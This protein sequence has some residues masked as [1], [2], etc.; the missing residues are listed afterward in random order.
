MFHGGQWAFRAT[1][2]I[3]YVCTKLG[4]FVVRARARLEQPTNAKI[5]ATLQF[6]HK[7]LTRTKKSVTLGKVGQRILFSTIHIWPN[8]QQTEI[9][10]TNVKPSIRWTPKRRTLFALAAG[11][12][13]LL[14]APYGVGSQWGAIHIDL[15]WS[16]FIPVFVA[17]ALGWRYAL[18]VGLAGGVYHPFVLWPNNGWANLGTSIVYLGL[19]LLVGFFRHTKLRTWVPGWGRRFVLLS[20]LSMLALW[21]YFSFV[22]DALLLLNPPWWRPDALRSVPPDLL[23]AFFLKDFI[24]LVLLFVF[25]DTL[26]QLP[27]VR[28]FFAL[29]TSAAQAN[30]HNIFFLSIVG[31]VV[32]FGG[33]VLVYRQLFHPFDSLDNQKL[34]LLLLTPIGVGFIVAR[35]VFYFN[36]QQYIIRRRL[37]RTDARYRALFRNAPDGI[38][39]LHRRRIS[40][41]N[42]SALQLFRA[43]EGYLNGTELLKLSPSYQNE[44]KT[45]A[46]LLANYFERAERGEAVH[47]EWLFLRPD[48]SYLEAEVSLNLLLANDP[49]LMQATLRDVSEKKH[50]LELLRQKNDAIAAANDKYRSANESL[51]QANQKL[52]DAK[53]TA[54]ENEGKFRTLFESSQEAIGLIHNG[55][56][57]MLN[58]AFVRLFGCSQASEVQH[59]PFLDLISPQAQPAIRMRLQQCIDTPD[60]VPM[61]ESCGRRADGSA[62]DFEGHLGRIW[63]ESQWHVLAILRDIGPR[64]QHEAELLQSHQQ[65]LQ[66]KEQ[67]E[68]SD[69]LKTAFLHN[70]SHE[71]RTPMNA[72][73]GFAGMLQRPRLTDEKRLRYTQVVMEN[74]KQLLTIIDDILAISALETQQVHH[75]PGPL[76][77]N[78]LFAK[79][80][81]T[82][83]PMAQKKGLDLTVDYGLD[84]RYDRIQADAY[85]LEMVLNHLLAN[86]LKFTEAGSIRLGYRVHQERLQCFVSDTGPGIPEA[87][88]ERLFDRFNKKEISDQK[89]H[90]GTGLGLA[91]CKGYANLMGGQLRFDTKL[92]HGT[93]FWLD[94]PYKPIGH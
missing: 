51:L 93:T 69:R 88:H 20:L 85:K 61:F 76:Y 17:L 58:R 74:T 33:F 81:D 45:S 92:G 29:N 44:H 7:C 23:N 28:R 1:S 60:Q 90:S 27:S 67:A 24:H 82:F 52:K 87:M 78:V 57:V 18:V 64:K 10:H 4:G 79:L 70:L 32:V 55:H 49:R 59:R 83:G 72:I 26:L 5:K 15:P 39:I 21:V 13:S 77:T 53:D 19:L 71:I 31:S 37:A 62:F 94:I 63:L 38:L 6:A 68:E 47:F 91:I 34:K 3:R 89:F 35:I 2:S 14:V 12:L 48:Q 73:V 16:L 36:E 56:V 41:Y 75:D 25:G 80:Y 30:N 54:E 43:T 22:Y 86:A 65:L 40:Q 8:R 66:A 46:S 84:N 9:K 42:P 50:S 11:L